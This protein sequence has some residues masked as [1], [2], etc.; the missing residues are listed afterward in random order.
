MEEK[1]NGRNVK[2]W[3]AI[4]LERTKDPKERTLTFADVVIAATLFCRSTTRRF[5]R[6]SK[7]GVASSPAGR[8]GPEPEKM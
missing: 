8:E 4:A 3:M 5:H 6:G 2:G 7:W 1:R